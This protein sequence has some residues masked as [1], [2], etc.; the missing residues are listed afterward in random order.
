MV[1][2][3]LSEEQVSLREIAH[4]FVQKEIRPVAWNY[5]RDGTWPRAIIDKAWG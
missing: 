4:D 3:T 5:D 1:D 2:F